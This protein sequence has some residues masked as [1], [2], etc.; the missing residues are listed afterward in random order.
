MSEPFVYIASDIMSYGSQCEAKRIEDICDRV[1]IPF[2]S[3]RLNMEINDKKA[4]SAEENAKLPEKIVKHD[5][6]MIDKATIFVV[7]YKPSSIG[8]IVELGQIFEKWRND[9]TIKVYG[10]YDD[11]RRTNIPEV[12]DRRSF[13]MNAYAFGVLATMSDTNELYELEDLEAALTSLVEK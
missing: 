11:I 4:C 13:G 10:L 1:G 8:T 9:N 12:G 3:A 6:A 5:T 7:N 2:Y